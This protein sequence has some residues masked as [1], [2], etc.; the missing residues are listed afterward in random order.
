MAKYLADA[1]L[2]ASLPHRENLIG[3]YA[4]E[5]GNRPLPVP[6]DEVRMV[7]H[8]TGD[9]RRLRAICPNTLWL[10]EVPRV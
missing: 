7:D 2:V 4:P 1:T 3:E 6:G 5:L 10:L 9:G 8:A